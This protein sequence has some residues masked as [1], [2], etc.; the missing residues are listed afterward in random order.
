M[1]KK[2]KLLEDEIITIKDDNGNI[3]TLYRIES[4]QDIR[5]DVTIGTKGG[6]IEKEDNLSHTGGCWV[7]DEAKVHGNAIICEDAI[8]YDRATVM[9]YAIC[10][11]IAQIYNSA[12][13]GGFA[14]ISNDARVFDDA[15]ISGCAIIESHARVFGNSTVTGISVVTDVAQIYDECSIISANISKLSLS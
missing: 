3:K 7:Y 6:F 13:I 12:N 9:D 2:Y 10:S 1:E 14:H 15:V 5:E 8:V 4:L 11:G